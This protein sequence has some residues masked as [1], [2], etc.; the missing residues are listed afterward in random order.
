MVLDVQGGIEIAD[1]NQRIAVLLRL[2]G[3]CFIK[4]LEKK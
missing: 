4:N 3:D 1:A 2:K